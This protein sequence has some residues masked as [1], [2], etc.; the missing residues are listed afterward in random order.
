VGLVVIRD[1]RVSWKPAFDVNRLVLVLAALTGFFLL[2]G[3]RRRR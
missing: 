3:R 1:G 2:L